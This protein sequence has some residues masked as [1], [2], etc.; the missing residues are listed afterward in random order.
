M[1]DPTMAHTLERHGMK[2]RS[3]GFSSSLRIWLAKCTDALQEVYETVIAHVNGIS[4]Q[5]PQDR[6]LGSTRC[7]HSELR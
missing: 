2:K 6:L 5:L 4:V 1:S 7:S 3:H